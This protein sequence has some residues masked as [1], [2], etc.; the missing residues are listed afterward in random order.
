VVVDE[1]VIAISPA[2]LTRDATRE[3]RVPAMKELLTKI[4]NAMTTSGR[5]PQRRAF[6]EAPGFLESD[7]FKDQIKKVLSGDHLERTLSNVSDLP[8][9]VLD[10][11]GEKCTVAE[12]LDL[13][14]AR[15][16]QLTGLNVADAVKARRRLLGLAEVQGRE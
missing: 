9:E 2:L 16:T 5:L 1:K 13:D 3:T 6:E 8:R 14:L 11:L 10:S 7:Y 4:Q 15:F 12:A